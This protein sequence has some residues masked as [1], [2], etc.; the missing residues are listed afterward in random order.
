LTALQEAVDPVPPWP[1]ELV[2]YPG[3]VVYVRRAPVIA[4][5]DGGRPAEPAVLVHGLGGSAMNWTD[6]VGLLREPAAGGPSIDGTA[7]DLPGFGY[8]PPPREG[9][10]SVSAHARAV[11]GL[12]ERL[13]TWP[14]HLIG[15]SMGGAVA[16][17]V[18]A[19][20]PDLVRTL[21]LI[22]PALPDVRP[23]L[24]PI[25]LAVAS[26]PAVGPA[27]MNTLRHLPAEQRTDRTIR[28]LYRD[29]G[30]LHPG[31]REEEIAEVR[32]RDTLEYADDALIRSARSLVTEYFKVGPRSLWGDAART[33]APALVL[34]GSHDRLVNPVMAAKAARAFRGGRGARVRVL[35]GVGHVA[36]M[37]RPAVVAAEIRAFLAELR[38]RR[39]DGIGQ[40]T[41]SGVI[42]SI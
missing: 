37:E 26:A 39:E 42:H 32:R 2:D 13:G 14:V 18:A 12:I 34:H 19:R 28:D 7:V 30:R 5:A 23:R 17:R 15:N 21:I 25:R 41:G 6:L 31:R 40:F 36:M 22:S 33:R 8:S 29:P 1:G 3:G 20:R 38:A 35:P 24:L 16:T 27:I 11:I 9:D 10:Y 4:A